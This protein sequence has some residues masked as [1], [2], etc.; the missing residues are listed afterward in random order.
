[1]YSKSR[2]LSHKGVKSFKP[3]LKLLWKTENGFMALID[4]LFYII[5]FW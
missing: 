4:L 3:D 5:T 2:E 1:M